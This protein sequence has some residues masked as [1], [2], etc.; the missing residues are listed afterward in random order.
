MHSIPDIALCDS[1]RMAHDKSTNQIN[2]SKQM[3][4]TV[5]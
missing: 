2:N 1:A 5:I 3:N 4:P